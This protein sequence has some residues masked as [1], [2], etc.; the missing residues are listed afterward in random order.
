VAV[1]RATQ[2]LIFLDFV[3][4]P[5][6]LQ[7]NY[8]ANLFLMDANC[9]EPVPWD[10]VL[11]R[12][13]CAEQVSLNL[14]KHALDDG[15]ASLDCDLNRAWI[16]A[17]QTCEIFHECIK[18]NVIAC[19]AERSFLALQ[20]GQLAAQVLSHKVFKVG[21]GDFE[22]EFIGNFLTKLTKHSELEA[23]SDGLEVLRRFK[24]SIA[25]PFE[26]FYCLLKPNSVQI[27]EGCLGVCGD[28]LIEKNQ[29][30]ERRPKLCRIL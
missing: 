30:I 10:A 29:S 11:S 5:G 2:A 12:L 15:R 20:V 25:N 18:G 23:I 9:V 16:R 1:S 27:F 26:V 6:D 14:L 13:E 19:D 8:G 28:R 17:R 21:I 7:E 24:A 3:E 22:N 4:S